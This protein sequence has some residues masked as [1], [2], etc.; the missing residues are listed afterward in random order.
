MEFRVLGPIEVI[1]DGRPL[2]LQSAKQKALL[3]LLIVNANRA[4]SV[5]RILDELWG[6]EPPQSGAKAV[7]FHIAKLRDLLEPGRAKGEVSSILTTGPAGYTLVAGPESID[8]VRFDPHEDGGPR[9]FR[10]D[11]IRLADDDRPADGRYTISFRD[12]AHETGSTVRII[13]QR[14][15]EIGGTER[16]L[17]TRSVGRAKNSFDWAVPADLVG[18]G[19]WWVRVEVTDPRGAVQSAVSSGPL[20]L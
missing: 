16:L 20:R 19:D 7:V 5:D 15:S 12:R 13:A 18:T 6:E 9:Q 2:V 14:G 10:L 17:A 11:W 4:L 8:M 3:A 1:T